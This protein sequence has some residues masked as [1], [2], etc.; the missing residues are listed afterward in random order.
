MIGVL[1]LIIVIALTIAIAQI[2]GGGGDGGSDEPQE[3]RYQ[4]QNPEC[5]KDG[6]KYEWS[7]EGDHRRASPEFAQYNYVECPQCGEKSG[8]LMTKCPECGKWY[9][10]ESTRNLVENAGGV[11]PGRGGRMPEAKCPHCGTVL[12]EYYDQQRRE[13]E[14]KD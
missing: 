10:S 12:S 14:G 4:C 13:R 8:L 7:P 11:P 2:V 3:V 6:K 5:A 9:V 1:G